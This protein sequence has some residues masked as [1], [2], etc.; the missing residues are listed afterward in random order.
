MSAD[1]H[2]QAN[3]VAVLR[4]LSGHGP[5]SVAALRA[6][7][8]LSRP[9]LDAIVTDLSA[10]RMIIQDDPGP[11]ARKT[12]SSGRPA[13]QFAVNPGAGFVAG[14]DVGRHKIV[15]CIADLTGAVR[16]ERRADVGAAADGAELVATVQRTLTEAVAEV[17]LAVGQLR[18]IALG[19]P[20]AVD[21]T[22]RITRSVVIPQWSGYDVGRVLAEWARVPVSINND[23][24]LAALAEQWRGAARLCQDVV[25]ILAGRRTRAAIMINGTVLTGRHG[26]AG[27]VGSVPELFFDTPQV[28]LG[29]PAADSERVAGVFTAARD[30]DRDSQARVQVFCRELARTLRFLITVL[31]PELVVIGGGLAAAGDQIIAGLGE[32]LRASELRTPLVASMLGDGAV[33]LGGVRKAQLL[34]GT[35]D[36]LVGAITEAAAENFATAHP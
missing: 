33:A 4:A 20:G 5:S 9:T 19:V 26:E 1:L 12:A 34:A 15:A 13:R 27:E 11:T 7:T 6:L 31:D 18:G 25:Y 24:N 8:G 2:R 17:P 10:G 14:I 23:A 28:L 29:D 36:P 21:A 30:G 35:D 3:T 16:V 22:G 32:H